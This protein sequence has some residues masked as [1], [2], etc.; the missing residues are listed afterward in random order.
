MLRCQAFSL[1]QVTLWRLFHGAVNCC[2]MSSIGFRIWRL[3]DEAG[4]RW[5]VWGTPPT[6]HQFPL[7]L[8]CVQYVDYTMV[9]NDFLMRY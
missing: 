1:S 8:C 3:H 2:H 9:A 6:L 4:L 7:R 5:V